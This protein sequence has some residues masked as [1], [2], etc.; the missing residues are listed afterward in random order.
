L[1]RKRTSRVR[2]RRESVKVLRAQVVSPRIFWY[3]FRR[4]LGRLLRLSLLLA[5]VGALGWGLWLAI[6]RGLIDNDEFRLRELVLNDNPVVDEIRLLEVGGI[7]L[8]GSLFDCDPGTIE[9]RLEAL[10]EVAGAAVAREFPG[11]LEVHVRARRPRF[12]VASVEAGVLPRD[13]RRG[14]LV[15]GA[16]YAFRCAPGMLERAEGLPVIELRGGEPRAGAVV[17]HPDYERAVRLFEV[18]E[19]E[20]PEAA[21]WVD[22]IRQHKGWASVVVTRDGTEAVFGHEEL[23]RQAGDLLAAVEHA[24]EKGARIE[25][26]HLIGRR[27]QPVTYRQPPAPRAI[28]VEEPA[29]AAEPEPDRDLQ[30]LLER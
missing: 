25:T 10:P 6:E 5:L 8:D 2:K 7:D 28:I 11:R 30:Q 22:R 9:A 17:E 18:L 1:F 27:N 24:R 26:I 14:L 13:R 16:G 23:E 29:A 15:D 19:D 21:G 12:W 20:L 4:A 3:D